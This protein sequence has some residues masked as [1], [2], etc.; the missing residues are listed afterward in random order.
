VLDACRGHGYALGISPD[1]SRFQ[2]YKLGEPALEPNLDWLRQADEVRYLDEH[3]E[4][5]P[6]EEPG[7]DE[8]DEDE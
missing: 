6:D 5:M 7:G 4:P 1:G 3:W 8:E 2:A